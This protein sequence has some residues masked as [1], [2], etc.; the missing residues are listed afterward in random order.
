MRFVS[1]PRSDFLPDVDPSRSFDL[2]SRLPIVSTVFISLK[3]IKRR[4]TTRIQARIEYTH[5]HLARF[6]TRK[7][8][9]KKNVD[10]IRSYV[11]MRSVERPWRRNVRSPPS[12]LVTAPSTLLLLLLLIARRWIKGVTRIR[13]KSALSWLRIAQRRLGSRVDYLRPFKRRGERAKRSRYKTCIHELLSSFL[14]LVQYFAIFVRL[15]RHRVL[16]LTRFFYCCCSLEIVYSI[17]VVILY[18]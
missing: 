16:F 10:G 15:R 1:V 12:K 4:C 8:E 3:K 14:H 2:P 9:G 18:T 11:C 6:V 7:G 5:V 13:G 17:G